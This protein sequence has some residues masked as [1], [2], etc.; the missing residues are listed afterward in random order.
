MKSENQRKIKASDR[1]KIVAA[2]AFVSVICFFTLGQ[3]FGENHPVLMWIGGL[4]FGLEAIW[5]L[6]VVSKGSNT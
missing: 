2:L 5:Q 1:F 4:G 3:P 6:Y